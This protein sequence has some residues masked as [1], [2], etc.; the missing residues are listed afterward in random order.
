MTREEM[1]SAVH[2]IMMVEGTDAEFE[3]W[4][5]QME[6]ELPNSHIG[7][8]IFYHRPELSAEQVVDEAIRRANTPRLL[9]R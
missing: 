6:N 5:L 1:V 9:L 4:M 2:G 7:D 8:L 3:A